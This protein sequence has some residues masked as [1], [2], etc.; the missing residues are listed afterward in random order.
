M[1]YKHLAH[2]GIS[3][4]ALMFSTALFASG[5]CDEVVPPGGPNG[6]Y[7]SQTRVTFLNDDGSVSADYSDLDWQAML[8]D[9]SPTIDFELDVTKLFPHVPLAGVVAHSEIALFELQL[10]YEESPNAIFKRH[11][12]L[13]LTASYDDPERWTLIFNW[14]TVA[15]NWSIVSDPVAAPTSVWT[16]DVPAGLRPEVFR[17]QL[18]P[19]VDWQSIAASVSWADGDFGRVVWAEPTGKVFAVPKRLPSA[20]PWRI[21]SGILS[22]ALVEAGQIAQLVVRSPHIDPAYQ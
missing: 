10:K 13:V 17:I 18:T 1:I 12:A 19:S 15:A 14:S 21:R 9:A 4:F 20:T 16:I 8:G 7:C 2:A 11:Q 3:T 22:G 6:G 5:Y